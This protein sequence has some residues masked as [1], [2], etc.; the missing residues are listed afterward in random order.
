M[1]EAASWMPWTPPLPRSLGAIA[2]PRG[3]GCVLG[4]LAAARL[5]RRLAIVQEGADA[6]VRHENAAPHRS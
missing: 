1:R 2:T 3:I 4:P 6:A 5:P